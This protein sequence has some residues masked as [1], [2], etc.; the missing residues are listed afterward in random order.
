MKTIKRTLLFAVLLMLALGFAAPAVAEDTA[1]EKT[2]SGF[3][4]VIQRSVMR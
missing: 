1:G 4:T 3:P 2:V